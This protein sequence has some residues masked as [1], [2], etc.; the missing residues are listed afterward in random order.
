[1][2]FYA[3][4]KK[5]KE[6]FYMNGMISDILSLWGKMQSVYITSWMEKKGFETLYSAC[7]SKMKR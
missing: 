1:M 2:K 4:V 7:M 5:K 6:A 3:A